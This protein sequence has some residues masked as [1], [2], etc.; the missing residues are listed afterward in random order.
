MSRNGH[1]GIRRD[2]RSGAPEGDA[3]VP[4]LPFDISDKIATTLE[5]IRIAWGCPEEPVG[6]HP[7]VVLVEDL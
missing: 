7:S 4:E 3:H 2:F 6:P 5:G 1:R